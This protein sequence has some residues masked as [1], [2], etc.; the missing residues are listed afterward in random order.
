MIALRERERQSVFDYDRVAAHVSFSAYA[1]ELVDARI[2]A[3]VRAVFYYHVTR[4]SRG[5][6]HDDAASNDAVVRHVRLGHNQTFVAY[7]GEHSAA[8][9]TAMYGHEFTYGASTTYARLRRLAPV[10]QILRSKTY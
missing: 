10:F 7:S 4:Q 1:T 9:R 3:Y 6:S 2:S 5:V 8:L